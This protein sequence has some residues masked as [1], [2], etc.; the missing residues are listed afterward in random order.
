MGR[1]EGTTVNLNQTV[2]L[3]KII[4]KDIMSFEL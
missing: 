2:R 1:Q 4:E 3:F